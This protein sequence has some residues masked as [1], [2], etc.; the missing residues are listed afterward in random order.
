MCYCNFPRHTYVKL[1][2]WIKSRKRERLLVIDEEM[3]IC[4]STTGPRI[5][6]I[7]C[8]KKHILHIETRTCLFFV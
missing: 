5:K 3:R 2:F 1:N 8:S 4:L 7:S 6:K